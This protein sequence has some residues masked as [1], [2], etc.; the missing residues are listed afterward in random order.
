MGTGASSGTDT[1]LA[2]N[3]FFRKLSYAP[4][5]GDYV[6]TAFWKCPWPRA[7]PN[8]TREPSASLWVKTEAK[9][10]QQFINMTIK[11]QCLEHFS[12]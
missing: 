10:F 6:Q 8:G 3:G 5:G 11:F 1:V 12:V 2:L 7:A 9:L 4:G